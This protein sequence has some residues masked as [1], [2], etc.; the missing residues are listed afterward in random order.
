MT[1]FVPGYL[2]TIT[3][4][5]DDLSAVGMVIDFTRTKASLP[6]AHF[7]TQYRRTASGQIS[8]TIQFD[9]HVSA[10]DLQKLEASFALETPVAFVMQ[11]GQASGATDAGQY[12]GSAIFTAFGVNGQADGEFEFAATLET[13]GPVTFTPPTP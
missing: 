13:D 1:T 12:T 4:G 7:G 6:K 2:G 8:G 9:G 11:I 5:S 10:E 3:I